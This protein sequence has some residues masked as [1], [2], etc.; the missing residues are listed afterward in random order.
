MKLSYDEIVTA[1]NYLWAAPH[2]P[3]LQLDGSHVRL[4]HPFGPSI[5]FDLTRRD[6]MQPI[7]KLT[8]TKL[9]VAVAALRKE[10]P[11]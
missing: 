8:Q 4:T 9:A 3:M 1:I 11:Q 7:E 6:L 5:V 10:L 2:P